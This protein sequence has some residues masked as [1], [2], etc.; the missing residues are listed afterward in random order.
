MLSNSSIR[1]NSN[2]SVSVAI[3]DYGL[4]NIA[5]IFNA[6]NRIEIKPSII[7]DGDELAKIRP[8]HVV[9]PGVGA[10]GNVLGRIDSF[11]SKRCFK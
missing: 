7:C 3:I 10:V 1:K 2:E 6:F 4:G 8:S 11:R 5:S 9:L